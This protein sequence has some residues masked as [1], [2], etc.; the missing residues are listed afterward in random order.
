ML[1]VHQVAS[2][3]A[4]VVVVAT[5]PV[6]QAQA[7][8]GGG[9]VITEEVTVAAPPRRVYDVLVQI[10]SWWDPAH[11]YSGDARNM[12]IDPRPGGCFCERWGDGAA[13]EHGR[14]IYVVPGQT[15]RWSGALGPLQEFGVTGTMTWALTA[16]SNGTTLKM[17]YA[18]SGYM[19]G[20]LDALAPVV[21]RVLAEQVARL[22]SF[23]E[24]GK[25]TP[26]PGR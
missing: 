2:A 25:V 1:N 4:L 10:G 5:S 19:P 21:K 16:A 26:A 13:I 20:G 9:F 7:P 11:T 24:T 23:I 14:V 6:V 8:A 12:S 18:A 22:K 3:T 17:M 15:I